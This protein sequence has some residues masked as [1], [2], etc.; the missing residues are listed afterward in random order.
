MT[1]S[2]THRPKT[3]DV[4][5]KK[6]SYLEAPDPGQYEHAQMM[7]ADGKIN[8]SKHRTAKLAVIDREARFKPIKSNSPGPML[9]ETVDN[10]NKT[11]RYVLSQR[12][13]EGTRPFDQ[14][15]KFTNIYWRHWQSNNVPGPAQYEKPSDFG[16]YGDVKYYKTLSFKG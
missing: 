13:G 7:P 12:R 8:L 6:L 9:Y 10:F 5:R 15:K 3:I 11:S 4:N 1:I 14:E 2:F 16:V